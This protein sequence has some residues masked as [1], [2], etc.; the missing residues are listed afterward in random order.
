MNNKFTF[1]L[2]SRVNNKCY[3]TVVT[4][5]NPMN[6]LRLL[7]QKYQRQDDSDSPIPFKEEDLAAKLFEVLENCRKSSLFIET[8]VDL[9]FNDN[10]WVII[11]IIICTES[12]MHIL[13]GMRKKKTKQVENN[14]R[15]ITIP[16]HRRKKD[17]YMLRWKVLSNTW[18]DIQQHPNRQLG[19]DTPSLWGNYH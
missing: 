9:D 11:I 13:E 14:N 1:L 10:W 18:R 17:H 5:V 4:M 8:D 7:H 15:R 6:V 12:I 19:S 3:C 16:V 2:N